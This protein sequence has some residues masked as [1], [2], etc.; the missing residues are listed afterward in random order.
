MNTR[1]LFVD[2]ETNVLSGLRRMLRPYRH[3]WTMDFANSG[4]EALAKMEDGGFDVV[5]TDMR[6][7]KMDGAQLLKI[8]TETYPE[9]IR[10]ILS[11]Q[12][13][14]ERIFRAIGATHQYLS[15]PCDAALLKATVAQACSLREA[16][17]HEDLKRAV[18]RISTI[19]CL[20]GNL[21][22]LRTELASN[23]TT[24]V[25]ASAIIAKDIGMTTNVLQLVSSAFFGSPREISDVH[26]ATS[27]LG[28]DLL[29]EL[30][31]EQE[32]FSAFNSSDAVFS[33]SEL[34]EHSVEVATAAKTIAEIETCDEKT[35]GHAYISG[36]LH[37][38]GKLV[39]AS[40]FP[41]RYLQMLNI[42][43]ANDITLRRAESQVFGSNHEDVGGYLLSLWGLPQSIVEAV[44]NNRICESDDFEKRLQL[45]VAGIASHIC[46]QNN[47]QEEQQG[48]TS[49][50]ALSSATEFRIPPIH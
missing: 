35:I 24:L 48:N 16:L 22:A 3:H 10:I 29:K 50:H 12:S 45:S 23:D 9:T 31:L 46:G 30:V 47:G 20:A 36:L 14:K 18:S 11:G 39:L 40:S 19:P 37:D 13:E 49:G 4:E 27:L 8:V 15:K 34:T 5:V 44:T 2:D 28:I 25:R 6:M 43:K 42:S 17:P 1:I 33:L 41:D 21:D 7:P 32:K 38:I 26:H